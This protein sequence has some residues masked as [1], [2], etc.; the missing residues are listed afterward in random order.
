MVSSEP[1]ASSSIEHNHLL[2]EGERSESLQNVPKI[3][4]ILSSKK[5]DTTN[6][7]TSLELSFLW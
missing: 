7:Y 6:L 4:R 1:L 2:S 5:G 3:L